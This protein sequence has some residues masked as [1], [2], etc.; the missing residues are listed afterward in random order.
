[1]GQ[2]A[3]TYANLTRDQYNDWLTRF[4]PKQK[5]LM[6]LATRHALMNQQLTRANENATQSLRSAQWGMQNQLARY[7]TPQTTNPDDHRLGLR[8]A[9]AMAGAKNGIR[10]VEQ[11][12]QMNLLTGG[13]GSLRQ[14][15]TLG[16]GGN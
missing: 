13:N 1:M 11:E 4:Y 14:Q 16:G 8:S 6:G 12:R 10:E 5:A 7:G 3:E 2:A 9:L 15:M